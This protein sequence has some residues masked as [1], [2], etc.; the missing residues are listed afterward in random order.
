[1]PQR[2]GFFYGDEFELTIDSEDA[3][4]LDRTTLTFGKH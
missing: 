4:P 2:S 3:G 1:L